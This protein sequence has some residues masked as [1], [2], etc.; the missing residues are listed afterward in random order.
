M[1]DTDNDDA[2]AEATDAVDGIVAAE[3]TATSLAAVDTGD[4][5]EGDVTLRAKEYVAED[6]GAALCISVDS[7]IADDKDSSFPF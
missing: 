1:E 7:G 6:V 5:V 3:D 4:T 2:D